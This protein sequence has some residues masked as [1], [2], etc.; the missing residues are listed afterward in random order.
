MLELI[1]ADA[2]ISRQ[3]ISSY[4]SII[5]VQVRTAGVIIR[6]QVKDTNEINSVD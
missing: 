4:L 5:D 3:D 1:K 6:S 2:T